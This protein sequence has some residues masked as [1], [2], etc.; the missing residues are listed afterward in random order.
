MAAGPAAAVLLEEVHVAVHTAGRSGSETAGRHSVR[1]LGGTCIVDR[2]LLHVLG[3]TFAALDALFQFCMGD[4]AA[5]DDRTVEQEEGRYRILG[6]IGQNFLHRTVQVDAHTVGMLGE[7]VTEVTEVLGYETDRIVVQSFEPDTVLIDLT[8]D[9]AVRAA[10]YSEADRAGR[11]V[12]GQT[13]HADIMGEV[14]AAELGSEPDVAG[15]LEELLLQ[16]DIAECAAELVT[17]GRQV[18]VILGRGELYGL[19]VGLSR[20]AAYDECDMIGRAGRSTEAIRKLS[21]FSG[22]SRALVS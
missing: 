14:L 9:V 15:S 17:G 19:E 20:G 11:T 16:L 8:L 6:Q 3:Q 22:L 10:G 2:M 4:V 18:V 1:G 13:D 5:H 7:T 21:S 12:T